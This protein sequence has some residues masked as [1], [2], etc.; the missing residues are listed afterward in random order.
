M[1]EIVVSVV[2]GWL[3]VFLA[4]LCNLLILKPRLLRAKL[5]RQGIKGPSPSVLFGNIDEMKR[6]Q[7]RV[8]PTPTTSTNDFPE[9]IAHDW[10]STLFPYLE[11]W[12]NEYGAALFLFSCFPSYL[13]E[14]VLI[15]VSILYLQQFP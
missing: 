9:A 10:P 3:I 1:A 14:K 8:H 4:H 11:Q 13:L 15:V 7:G 2:L 5:Q 12:K 6:L